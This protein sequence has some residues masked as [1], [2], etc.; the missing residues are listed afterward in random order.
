MPMPIIKALDCYQSKD[1]QKQLRLITRRGGTGH[2][3]AEEAIGAIALWSRG[4]N[5]DLP[6]TR[7]GESRIR[8]VVKYDLRGYFRLVVYEHAGIRVPLFIGNHDDVDHWLESNK[9]SDFH[10]DH[11][12]KAASF[13]KVNGDRGDSRSDHE[14]LQ[15]NLRASG[16]LLARV[17]DDV[18]EVLNLPLSTVRVLRSVITFENVHEQTT[19]DILDGL[20]YP[21]DDMK[22][23][24][25]QAICYMGRGRAQEAVARLKLAAEQAST[26]S[27]DPDGFSDAMQSG[28]NS[29]TLVNL[30]DLTSEE[31]QRLL[32]SE[33]FADWMLFLHPDQQQFVKREYSGPARLIGVAGSGKTVVL[34]HRARALAKKY[35][36]ERILVLTL[37]RSL[38]RLINHLL[39]RLCEEGIRRQIDVCSMYDCCYALVKAISPRQIIEQHDPRSGEDLEAC[40]SD[41]LEKDHADLIAEPVSYALENRK[42]KVHAPS[43]L[44][45]ELIWIRSGF[46]LDQRNEYLSCERRGRGIVFRTFDP[47]TA[48]EPK[49][50]DVEAMPFD[51]R[52]RML[53]LLEEYEDYMAAGGLLDKDG[54]SLLAFSLRDR[55]RDF[56][57]VCARCVLVDEVQ[58]FSTVELAVVAEL[59]TDPNDGLFLCGDPVQKVFPKQHNLKDAGVDIVGRGA[60]LR[61]NYRNS[62]QILEGAFRI[63][64]KFWEDAAIASADIIRPEYAFRDSSKPILYDCRSREEEIDLLL[65]HLSYYDEAQLDAVCVCSPCPT[66]L[67]MFTDRCRERGIRTSTLTGESQFDEV[68]VKVS[69]LEH[70]KGYEFAVVFLLDLSD[71]LLPSKGMPWEERWRDA[72]Q[73]YVAMTRARDELVMMYVNNR[74]ILI[75]PLGDSV[76]EANAADF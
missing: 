14:A 37:G 9:G 22:A 44:L 13:T 46:G 73:I 50:R 36:G 26:A 40:W 19:Y 68:G 62:R 41:F 49:D 57:A 74:S 47:D 12:T 18:L 24:V 59:P 75:G 42:D 6:T 53:Q 38:V 71:S 11:E 4:I 61:R 72:F 32:A 63:V 10:F 58:D 55:I 70:V 52:R 69:L 54:V 56:P 65:R 5:P 28:L 34:V 21:S 20:I 33:R 8:H 25:L 16:P 17:P 51:V 76:T 35:P 48:K 66:T 60:L 45:D 15:Q 64:E 31:I 2:A 30:R 1:F 27:D 7:H 3:A 23:A 43:Y 39:D 29:D 67:S